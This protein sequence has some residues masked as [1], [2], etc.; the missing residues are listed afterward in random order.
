MKSVYKLFFDG[1]KKHNNIAYGYV[2]YRDD[3]QI[4]KS[5]G[6][7]SHTIISSNAAEYIGLICGMI[8]A[9]ALGAKD[10]VIR[11]DSQLI[12]YQIQGKYKAKSPILITLRILSKEI[13]KMFDSC[14]IDWVPREDNTEADRTCRS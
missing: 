13:I 8:S 14:D 1:G 4:H 11:G 2:I 6:K 10:I 12:I 9:L 3:E 7:F 5:H